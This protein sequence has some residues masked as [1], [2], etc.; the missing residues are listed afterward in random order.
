MNAT[1]LHINGVGAVSSAGWSG[2]DLLRVIR[3]REV[4][5]AMNY[6][7]PGIE[8]AWNCPVRPVPP[9]PPEKQVRH[10]RFRRVSAITRYAAAASLEALKDAGFDTPPPH[11]GILFVMMN[12]CVSYTGRFYQEVLDNPAQA[13]PLI[14]PETV[15]NAP[16][17]HIAALL[18]ADG[19][20]S[21]I[22][23]NANAIMEAL[24]MAAVWIRGG[25]IDHCL[26]IGAEEC[27]WLSA[28]ALTYYHEA[29]I[30]SEGAGALLVSAE[31]GGPRIQSITGP[32]AFHS[33][34][35]RCEILPRLVQPAAILI[36]DRNG[37]PLHDAAETAA[38]SRLDFQTRHSPKQILGESMGASAILQLVLATLES[39]AQN[40]TAVISMPGGNAAA[41]ACVI[42]HSA[43]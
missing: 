15:F 16:A 30:A 27:D 13:S 38:W 25:L 22:I 8:R 37:I 42:A 7:R 11:L 36:D 18:G 5:P 3:A 34:K 17:S 26:I 23:G 32:L 1:G 4:L 43:T 33:W 14:F 31:G 40:A 41:Y 21:T 19:A 35:E 24:D 10:P 20:V 12:G 29:H 6:P 28:E 39:R 9:M 2:A